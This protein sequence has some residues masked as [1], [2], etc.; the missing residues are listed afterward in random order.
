[1]FY[2][3]EAAAA[4]PRGVTCFQR[5]C[6]ENTAFTSCFHC[7]LHWHLCHVF[8]LPL[9]RRHCFHLVNYLVNIK[10]SGTFGPL[11][12][13]CHCRRPDKTLPLPRV[14]IVLRGQAP[15]CLSMFSLPSWLTHWLVPVWVV[16][17]SWCIHCQ[18]SCWHWFY[19]SIPMLSWRTHCIC[20]V[21]FHCLLWLRRN[22]CDVY[23]LSG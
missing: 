1:M 9:M 5:L 19:L 12:L 7:L 18:A 2:L 14:S 6:C 16:L 17:P 4:R 3:Y 8:P 10:G 15:D 21:I 22:I 11:D 13:P 20:L 23:P